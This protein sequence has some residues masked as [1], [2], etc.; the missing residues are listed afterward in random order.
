MAVCPTE[1]T[2]STNKVASVALPTARSRQQKTL[3]NLELEIQKGSRVVLYPIRG[4][5]EL[6]A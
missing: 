3:V 6:G 4:L 2:K 5:V 1:V